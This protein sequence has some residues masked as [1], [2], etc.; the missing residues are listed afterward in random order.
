MAHMRAEGQYLSGKSIW[1]TSGNNITIENV[2][3]SG[4]AVPDHNGAGIRS[5]GVDLKVR[6]CYFHDNENGI[7]TNSPYAGEILIEFCEF[8]H[9]GFGDGY[10]HNVYINHVDKLTFQFNY[11]HHANV[12]HNLKSR[13]AENHIVCNRI[14]DEETGNSSRLIDLPDGGRSIVMGNLLMQGDNAVNN[15][16][17]G[18]GLEGLSNPFPEFYFINNTLVNKRQASCRFLQ[19]QP[20]TTD[21]RVINNIFAG[22][23][24]ILEGNA[25]VMTNNFE[26]TDIAKLMFVDEPAY[27]YRLTSASPVIEGG[28]I[29]DSAG[30]YSLQQRS[31]YLHPVDSATRLISGNPDIGCYE[32]DA[33]AGVDQRLGPACSVW[34]NP[35]RAGYPIQVRVPGIPDLIQLTDTRTGKIVK[36]AQKGSRCE[37]DGILPGFYLIRICWQNQVYFQKL[38]VL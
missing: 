26:E 15:N 31:V 13:A 5:E 7:L 29:P 1:I 12:G 28:I 33:Q 2:E 9:N 32:Y 27:D 14:M 21:A 19:I 35:V 37:T 3:F 30:I 6:H 4:C 36:S 10:S 24:T 20:G 18:Y 22:T 8:S 34:P 11:S 25:T 16:M 23:G 38:I 17:V